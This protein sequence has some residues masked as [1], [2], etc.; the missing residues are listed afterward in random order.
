MLLGLVFA[1]VASWAE[2]QAHV[3]VRAGVSGDPGQFVF[4][5]H[6]ETKPILT[7]MTFRPNI[8]VGVGDA[9]TLA[10]FNIEFAYWIPLDRKPWRV[11]L[12]GGPALVIRSF[13]GDNPGDTGG[14]DAGG[15]LNFMAGI[16][17]SKGLFGEVKVG[18]IDSPSVKVM[19]GYAFR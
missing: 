1:S 6:I 11:Y 5:G 2:A 4:G 17:H 13:R 9:G 10:A 8:E 12:G 16:Q 15:G 7:Q 3:G 19:V 18:L 14:S